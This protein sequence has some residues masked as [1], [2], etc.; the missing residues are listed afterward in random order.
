LDVIHWQAIVG[1]T[2]VDESSAGEVLGILRLVSKK[3]NF[4]FFPSISKN[5]LA[6]SSALRL[7][8][9]SRGCFVSPVLRKENKLMKI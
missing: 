9:R 3:L 2:R 4:S 5:I 7:P 8:L 6:A 1:H